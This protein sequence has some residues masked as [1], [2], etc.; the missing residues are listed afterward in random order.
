MKKKNNKSKI[1]IFLENYKTDP[2]FKA[3]AQL[4]A[5]GIFIIGIIIYVNIASINKGSSNTL[6]KDNLTNQSKLNI[7]KTQKNNLLKK[8]TNNYEY[9]I[10]VNITEETDESKTNKTAIFTGK[11]YK[12]DLE[13]N[14]EENDN[15][16]TYYKLNSRYYTKNNETYESITPEEIYTILEKEY[17]ELS[18]IK[19]YIDNSSLD[20]VTDY[21]SGKKEYVYHLKVKE[22]M[23]NYPEVDEIEISIIEENDILTINIDYTNLMKLIKKGTTSCKVEYTYK[24]I[25]NVEKF[26]DSEQNE[27]Q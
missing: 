3:K 1:D 17:I 21:S 12:N 10:K 25:N 27:Q 23:K 8:I 15:K 24:N 9:E 20:H 7:T 19:E 22:I 18:Y 5:W 2:K 26:I 16:N 11:S 4:A 6:I 14:K 13:I